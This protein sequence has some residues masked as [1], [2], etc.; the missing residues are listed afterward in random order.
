MQKELKVKLKESREAYGKKL[1]SKLQ[2]NNVKDVWSGM[3][4]ITGFK[5]KVKQTEGEPGEGQ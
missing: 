3:K 1:E 5:A 4:T 2:Q